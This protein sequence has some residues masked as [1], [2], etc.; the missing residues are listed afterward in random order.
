[1]TRCG[2]FPPDVVYEAVDDHYSGRNFLKEKTKRGKP[3]NTPTPNRT[4]KS[5][6]LENERTKATQAKIDKGGEQ[7]QGFQEE[8]RRQKCRHL[9]KF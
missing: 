3:P 8:K 4:T 1:M 2:I 6:T 9:G 7:K 5:T